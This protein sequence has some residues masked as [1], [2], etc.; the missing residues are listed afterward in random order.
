MKGES[1]C[2]WNIEIFC[3]SLYCFYLLKIRHFCNKSRTNFK[4]VLYCQTMIR[5]QGYKKM[6][7]KLDEVCQRNCFFIQFFFEKEKYQKSIHLLAAMP[8]KLSFMKL[9]ILETKSVWKTQTTNV[10]LYINR[11]YIKYIFYYRAR[12]NK[13]LFF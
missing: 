1:W 11:M 6:I 7:L 2:K 4:V 3:C 9:L 12:I 5:V 13:K 8:N 10:A